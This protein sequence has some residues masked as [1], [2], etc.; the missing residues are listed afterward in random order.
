VVV[1]PQ[2]QCFSHVVVVAA[3]LPVL[4][5]VSH[6]PCCTAQPIASSP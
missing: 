2:P 4:V 6:A 5:V 1:V 3:S